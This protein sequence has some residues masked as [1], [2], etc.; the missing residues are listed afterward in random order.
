MIFALV[1]P[2]K[3][4]DFFVFIIQSHTLTSM[5]GTTSALRRSNEQ[6]FS[7]LLTIF[8]IVVDPSDMSKLILCSRGDILSFQEYYPVR[9]LCL[10]SILDKR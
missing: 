6:K 5:M 9:S 3:L 4:K 10:G 2:T 7:A 8:R 1:F